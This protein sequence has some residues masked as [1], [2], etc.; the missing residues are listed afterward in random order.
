M[1]YKD[2]EKFLQYAGRCKS[3]ILENWEIID[4][5]DFKPYLID[6]RNK[7]E[8]Y[9]GAFLRKIEQD[10]INQNFPRPAS[11]QDS[12]FTWINEERL[13]EYLKNR[14]PDFIVGINIFISGDWRR[15]TD[16]YFIWKE[17][18]D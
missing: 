14:Y 10:L 6:Y 12:I 3:Q 11:Y 1:A 5:I 8:I 9:V 4:K 7:K 18:K 2:Y 13:A 17:Q 15:L 16:C